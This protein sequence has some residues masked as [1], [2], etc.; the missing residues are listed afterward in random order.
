MKVPL[1]FCLAEGR[2]LHF[3]LTYLRHSDRRVLKFANIDSSKGTASQEMTSF[4]IYI[5]LLFSGKSLELYVLPEE[6]EPFQC[7]PVWGYCFSD[8]QVG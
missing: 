7:N 3:P 5:F 4:A 6:K 2:I 1:D 8:D